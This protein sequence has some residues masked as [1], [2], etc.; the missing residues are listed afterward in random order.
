MKHDIRQAFDAVHAEPALKEQTLAFLAQRR[1]HPWRKWAVKAAL[2]AAACAAL[3]GTGGWLWMTPTAAVQVE[4]GAAV[5]LGINRFD[6]VVSVEGADA[7]QVRALGLWL[8]DCTEA[9]E[10]LLAGKQTSKQDT[11]LTVDGTD[12]T[13]CSRLLQGLERCTDGYENTYCYAAGERHG[14]NRQQTSAA[15]SAQQDGNSPTG[16]QRHH[17]G[18]NSGASS[19]D[20]PGNGYG[21]GN[22]QGNGQGNGGHHNRR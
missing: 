14:H 18:Q 20:S 4:G 10:R 1:A 8:M 3:L 21:H 16:G 2:C 17:A 11:T 19:T 6:R 9:V 15:T 13:Q 22:G 5:E 12:D 7:E